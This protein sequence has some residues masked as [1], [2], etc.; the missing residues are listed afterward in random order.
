MK[1]N[2]SHFLITVLFFAGFSLISFCSDSGSEIV[3]AVKPAE[4]IDISKISVSNAITRS[5]KDVSESVEVYQIV[6]DMYIRISDFIDV[7]L[8]IAGDERWLDGNQVQNKKKLYIPVQSVL[9]EDDVPLL[10]EEITLIQ[11]GNIQ[12]CNDN[13]QLVYSND[14]GATWYALTKDSFAFESDKMLL[15]KKLSHGTLGEIN[16]LEE[17]DPIPVDIKSQN[18]GVANISGT[19]N[20][21]VVPRS[22]AKITK[23]EVI[24][25]KIIFNCSLPEDVELSDCK[26][27]WILEPDVNGAMQKA[28]EKVMTLDCSK[29]SAEGKYNVQFLLKGYDLAGGPHYYSPAQVTFSV[30][31]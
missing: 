12:F 13:E 17:S 20:I 18:I 6:G 27:T 5:G 4:L 31:F 7:E 25:G 22:D 24:S 29:L 26:Y 10:S 11:N 14:S 21:N 2:I 16:Y 15:V 23:S 1:R 3:L 8:C 30:A 9:K 19:G 28:N